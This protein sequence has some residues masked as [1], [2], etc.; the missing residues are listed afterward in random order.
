MNVR[1]LE[2]GA[3]GHA[4][5]AGLT[6]ALTAGIKAL[7]GVVAIGVHHAIH[8]FG[9]GAHECVDAQKAGGCDQAQNDPLLHALTPFVKKQQK[10]Y[11]INQ[12]NVIYNLFF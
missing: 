1:L 6:G 4:F 9:F 5:F 11:H 3:A 7:A 8:G 10:I 12:L 2:S